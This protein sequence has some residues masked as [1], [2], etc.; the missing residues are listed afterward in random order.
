MSVAFPAIAG[1]LGGGAD[2]AA[3][4]ASSYSWTSTTSAS[5]AQTLV[6]RNGAGLESS[7]TFTLTP[8]TTAPS[9]Q[10]VT[11]QDLSSGASGDAGAM[12]AGL[13]VDESIGFGVDGDN[14]GLAD[15]LETRASTLGS[16][17]TVDVLV[18]P[19]SRADRE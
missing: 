9:G 18:E 5:G 4:Y 17:A 15:D 12:S 8:D 3:P 11:V 2:T 10:T 1:L 6:A 14:D 16:A 7:A 19:R 13:P